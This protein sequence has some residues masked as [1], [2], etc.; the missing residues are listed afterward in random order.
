M[1]RRVAVAAFLF[2]SLVLPAHAGIASA[3]MEVSFVV[4]AACTVEALGA[5][6]NVSCN[7]ASPYRVAPALATTVNGDKAWT[8]TF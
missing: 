8:V 6:P 2:S 4:K 3:S 5:V 7:D 1:I